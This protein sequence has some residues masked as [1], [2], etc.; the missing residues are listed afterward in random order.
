[1][2]YEAKEAATTEQH[3]T[4]FNNLPLSILILYTELN[5][6]FTIKCEAALR[7]FTIQPPLSEPQLWT[8][9]LICA[10]AV[11]HRTAIL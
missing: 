4:H 9:W 1:M 3:T 6:D 5:S 7:T 2:V 8:M 11:H 10:Y